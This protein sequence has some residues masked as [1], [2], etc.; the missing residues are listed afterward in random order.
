MA[1]AVTACQQGAGP[2]SDGDVTAIREALEQHTQGVL[3]G[4]LDAVAAGYT[5]DA[6][7]MPPNAPIVQGR[8]NI[9]DW[10]GGFPAVTQYD[11]DVQEIEGSGD[12]AYVR[13]AYIITIA[14]GDDSEAMTET[15]KNLVILKKQP[16]GSWIVSIGIWNS[17]EPVPPMEG[18][19]SAV[20]EHS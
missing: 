3:A 19:H 7:Q 10:F 14:A 1:L 13:G 4:D 5:E 16:D 8:D 2:L 11:I 15:G 12:M 6:I 17:D 20:G 9:R 18:E